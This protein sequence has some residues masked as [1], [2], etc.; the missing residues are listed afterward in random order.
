MKLSKQTIVIAIILSIVLFAA[1]ICIWDKLYML[2][3]PKIGN[4]KY[5]ETSM[6]GQYIIFFLPCLALALIPIAAILVWRYAPVFSMQR[7][8]LSVGIITGVMIIS[9]LARR[10]MISYK[11]RQ[12]ELSA[13]VDLPNPSG[14][15]QIGIAT[16]ELRFE[17]YILG[18]LIAGSIISF[19]VLREKNS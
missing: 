3:L 10:E 6:T 15:V 14:P 7:K 9:V 19:F 1:G 18:G 8:L 2:I 5:F 11:A 12:L 4:V 13:L 17:Q 16:S